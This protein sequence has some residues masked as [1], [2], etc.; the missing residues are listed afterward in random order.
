[1]REPREW[2]KETDD[3]V[4]QRVQMRSE[5]SRRS[6]RDCKL[7]IPRTHPCTLFEKKEPSPLFAVA[8]RGRAEKPASHS[9]DLFHAPS[10]FFLQNWHRPIDGVKVAFHSPKIQSTC[11]LI[12]LFC[13]KPSRAIQKGLDWY[14]IETVL[15]STAEI[16]LDGAVGLMRAKRGCS[17]LLFRLVRYSRSAFGSLSRRVF[18]IGH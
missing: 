14:S 10:A 3:C 6:P 11:A 12:V 1:M 5:R 4:L 16:L 8:Q 7:K 13:V 9:A 2:E 17:S 18:Y 15:N